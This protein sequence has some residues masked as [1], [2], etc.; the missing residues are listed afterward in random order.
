VSYI[1]YM[2]YNEGSLHNSICEKTKYTLSYQNLFYFS[3]DAACFGP[4][5]AIIRRTMIP[6]SVLELHVISISIHIVFM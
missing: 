4:Y 3:V 5:W 1:G 2:L 6:V